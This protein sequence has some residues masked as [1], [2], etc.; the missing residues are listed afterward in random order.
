MTRS[1]VRCGLALA[2]ASVL[3]VPVSLASAKATPGCVTP[4]EFAKATPGK[5]VS[6]VKRLFGTNGK[7]SAYSSG[8]GVT[9]EIRSYKGCT[10]FGTVAISYTN[11][12]LTAKS[13]VF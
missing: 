3:L 1:I 13:G 4:A 12:K 7:R 2:C 6:Q 10:Q 9:I 11:G 8:Y 5:T